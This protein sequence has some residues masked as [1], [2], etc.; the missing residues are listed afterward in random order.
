MST[1]A[2][3]STV[4]PPLAGLPKFHPLADIDPL[5]D[6]ADYDA[7]VEDI[8][9]HGLREPLVLYKG[10]ILDGRNRARACVEAGVE[11]AW[12]EMAFVDDD[13]AAAFVNSI[14]LHRRHL[15]PE[16]K[17]QRI[18]T[19]LKA[20]PALSDRQVAKQTRTSHPRVARV[21]RKLE[22]S[23]DVE[24]RST[25]TDTKGRSQP[26]RR[27][28]PAKAKPASPSEHPSPTAGNAEPA[29]ETP[30]SSR[31]AGP[32]SEGEHDRLRARN[33]ELNEENR[34]L[35]IQI[36][37]LKS[38]ITE[39]KAKKSPRGDQSEVEDLVNHALR[40][41]EAMDADQ[42]QQFF[43]EL[44]KRARIT[45]LSLTPE[46]ASAPIVT[47]S[48]VAPASDPIGDDLDVRSFGGGSLRR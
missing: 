12:R 14:N 15:T 10:K 24:R 29:A 26:R 36:V 9:T 2:V 38:E 19:R 37:G 7:L 35:E 6:G 28:K 5:I 17:N 40:L 42:R 20:N 47:A 31:D 13:A 33:D 23:G 45:E 4:K 27:S 18:A 46:T 16:Q 48:A 30:A 39:A 25:S 21:R 41:V 8:R 3:P 44:R 1:T 32:Y 22:K 34:R 43:A 11:L